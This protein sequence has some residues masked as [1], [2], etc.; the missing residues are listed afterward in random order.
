MG[1]LLHREVELRLN[2]EFIDCGNRIG[3]EAYVKHPIFFHWS[4]QEIETFLPDIDSNGILGPGTY[5]AVNNPFGLKSN[6]IEQYRIERSS[7]RH[8]CTFHGNLLC[9]NPVYLKQE[10]DS[11][12]E[13]FGLLSFSNIIEENK[14]TSFLQEQG[15]DG[16]CLYHPPSNAGEAV[17]FKPWE[18][19][20]I[21]KVFTKTT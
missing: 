19:V 21:D 8:I 5:F 4:F 1:G 10:S 18:T 9:L 17:V 2:R 6:R 3:F 12:W 20:S 11:L 7:A 13:R 16:I 14:R 15:F